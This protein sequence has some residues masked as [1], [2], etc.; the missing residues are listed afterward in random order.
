[1]AS[2]FARSSL[3]KN[4]AALSVEALEDRTVPTTLHVGTGQTYLSIQDALNAANSGDTIQLEQGAGVTANAASSTTLAASVSSGAT[5]LSVTGTQVQAGDVLVIDPGTSS[6]EWVIVDSVELTSTGETITLSRPLTNAHAAGATVQT[7]GFLGIGKSLTVQ[8]DPDLAPA[9]QAALSDLY[10]ANTSGVSLLNLHLTDVTLLGS[11][12][13]LSGSRIDGNVTNDVVLNVNGVPLPIGGGSGTLQ[14]LGSGGGDVLTGNEIAGSVYLYGTTNELVAYNSFQ[15]AGLKLP[16]VTNFADKLHLSH[17]TNS[18]VSYN[19]LS[20]TGTTN[21]VDDAILVDDSSV[22]FVTGNSVLLKANATGDHAI[23][24]AG[25]DEFSNRVN[26]QV[27]VLNNVLNT[28]ATGTGLFLND[29]ST[30]TLTSRVQGNDFHNDAVGVEINGDGSD[31]LPGVDLGS[32]TSPSLTQSLGGND[33]RD[34]LYTTSPTTANA[35]ILMVNVPS[36]TTL[37]ARGNLFN[38]GI[39]DPHSLVVDGGN[40]GAGTIDVS[41]ALSP[42]RAYVDSLYNHFLDRSA[43]AQELSFWAGQLPALGQAGVAQQILHSP[44]EAVRLVDGFFA[45]Y[46]H[47][48]SDPGEAATLQGVFLQSGTEEAT[49]QAFFTSGDY[50]SWAN[51]SQAPSDAA[52]VQSL[53][54]NLFSRQA[55]TSGEQYW[56]GMVDSSGSGGAAAG[57]VF[58]VEYRLNMVQGFYT[59]LLHQETTPSQSQINAWVAPTTDLLSLAVQFVNTSSFYTNG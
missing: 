8:G 49:L 38:S 15:G 5:S 47:N 27:D 28:A 17:V 14:K 3:R 1:M 29:Y 58:S 19:N 40:T 52:F 37:T 35:A 6:A 4:R 45:A 12:T 26:T 41:Q 43:T 59:D 16:G 9:G 33:F 36:G 30:S 2:R 22:V 21:V 56:Q 44:E 7:T 34:P 57:L 18:S 42:D 46:L 51:Q 11:D 23:E 48:L 24:V 39:S 53:Y 25:S 54:T 10:V 32:T 20:V 13:T 55:D 31:P 50:L